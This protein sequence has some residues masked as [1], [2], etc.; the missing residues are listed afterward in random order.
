MWREKS[1]QRTYFLLV[2]MVPLMLDLFL[3]ATVMGFLPLFPHFQAVMVEF[4]EKHF[5]VKV[6]ISEI[7]AV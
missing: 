4:F 3:E 7:I 2:E 6:P 5:R 1:L